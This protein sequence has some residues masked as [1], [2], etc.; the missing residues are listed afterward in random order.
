MKIRHYYTCP[1]GVCICAWLQGCCVFLFFI[2]IHC[3]HGFCVRAK[4]FNIVSTICELVSLVSPFSP[5]V[6]VFVRN[7]NRLQ[8]LSPGWTQQMGEHWHTHT[9]NDCPGG[10]VECLNSNVA[11]TLLQGQWITLCFYVNGKKHVSH[12]MLRIFSVSYMDMGTNTSTLILSLYDTRWCASEIVRWQTEP[13]LYKVTMG[14]NHLT[15]THT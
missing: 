4:M 5:N 2:F 14:T 10:I 12:S 6:C 7:P 8:L 3:S 15:H 1:A 13:F 11:A 9:V